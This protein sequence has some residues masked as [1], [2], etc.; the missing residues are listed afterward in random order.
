LVNQFGSEEEAL[1]RIEADFE[2]NAK[3]WTEAGFIKKR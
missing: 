3:D 1:R 2:I